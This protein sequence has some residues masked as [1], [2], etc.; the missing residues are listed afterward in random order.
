MNVGRP[1]GARG[2]RL[3]R[4]Q[5]ASRR[6]PASAGV[7]PRSPATAVGHGAGL[8]RSSPRSQRST[9]SSAADSAVVWLASTWRGSISQRANS[10]CILRAAASSRK[11]W[12]DTREHP[13]D[14]HLDIGQQHRV[15]EP[16]EPAVGEEAC[17]RTTDP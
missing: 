5:Q 4:N 15:V 6:A 3:A 10:W 11:P 7:R 12:L 8:N 1:S 16:V 2:L 14:A 9:I 13:L 17:R